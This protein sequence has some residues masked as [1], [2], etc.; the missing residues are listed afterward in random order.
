MAEDKK[1]KLETKVE[2]GVKYQKYEGTT[3]WEIVK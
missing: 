2:D 1:R 3:T